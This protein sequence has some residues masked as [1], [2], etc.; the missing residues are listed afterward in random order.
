MST[1]AVTLGMVGIAHAQTYNYYP[2]ERIHCMLNDTEALSCNEFDRQYLI[3][4]ATNADLKKNEGMTFHFFSAVAFFTPN[5]E[6]SSI[7]FT[8]HNHLQKVVKLKTTDFSLKPDL[9]N[10][11]WKQ[12]NEDIYIC[13]AGYMH[14]P[15]TNVPQI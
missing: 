12:L 8:Y 9:K 15:I 2:P 7:F 14:C 11:A 6:E 5:K 13:D 4:D 3:E 10:G 1:V